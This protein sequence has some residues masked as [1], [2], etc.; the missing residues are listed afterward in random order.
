MSSPGKRSVPGKP[1][2]DIIARVDRA[3]APWKGG[4]A[5]LARHH[6]QLHG[7]A[8][9]T[10]S[11]QVVSL[12]REPGRH[13]KPDVRARLEE[14]LATWDP[15]SMCAPRDPATLPTP[16]GAPAPPSGPPPVDEMGTDDLE[17]LAREVHGELA[18]RTG[19]GDSW[20]ARADAGTFPG[21]LWDESFVLVRPPEVPEPEAW[22]RFHCWSCGDSVELRFGARVVPARAFL[23]ERCFEEYVP[24]VIRDH[25][26]AV[27]TG[28]R[29]GTRYRT[30]DIA[31]WW[32]SVLD[33]IEKLEQGGKLGGPDE[34]TARNGS[35]RPRKG[36]G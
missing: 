10:L 22:N 31:E 14:S 5:A 19:D 27:F 29:L 4:L 33:T 15:A 17:A 3:V 13:M 9:D 11:K 7:L 32:E 35:E 18:R 8:F 23:C 20:D 1:A 6:G 25:T 28:D 16:G 12:R 30:A 2:A 26:L 24:P 34:P 36:G 21:P